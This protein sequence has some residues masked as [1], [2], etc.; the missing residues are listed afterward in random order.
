MVS[1]RIPAVPDTVNELPTRIMHASRFILRRT[2]IGIESV[3]SD[4]FQQS[5]R[6]RLARSSSDSTVGMCGGRRSRIR[7]VDVVRDA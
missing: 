3:S 1:V 5:T 6:M 7:E 2:H 4:G